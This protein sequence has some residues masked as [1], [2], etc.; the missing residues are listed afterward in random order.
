MP[1]SIGADRTARL[2][3]TTV[4]VPFTTTAPLIEDTNLSALKGFE[5][6]KLE[7][8]TNKQA[9]SPI[10]ST[11]PATRTEIPA[12]VLQQPLSQFSTLP[13]FGN[14]ASSTVTPDMPE[15]GKQYNSAVPFGL[16]RPWK[17][18]AVSTEPASSALLTFDTDNFAGTVFSRDSGA[19]FVFGTKSETVTDSKTDPVEKMETEDGQSQA[20]SSILDGPPT[21][22]NFNSFTSLIES[23]IDTM[24]TSLSPPTKNSVAV[25]D[26]PT[27]SQPCA[28]YTVGEYLID[29]ITCIFHRWSGT[30][31]TVVFNK[32]AELYAQYRLGLSSPYPSSWTCPSAS[33]NW[34]GVVE[35]F[36]SDFVELTM[37]DATE[38]VKAAKVEFLMNEL[39]RSIGEECETMDEDAYAGLRVCVQIF[40][41]Q[42]GYSDTS[43]RRSECRRRGG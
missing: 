42:E 29:N 9:A 24:E 3:S 18:P 26:A 31:R 5:V 1:E 28:P 36:E 7:F 19:P 25:E 33:M 35:N 13:L 23:C 39:E 11:H 15:C 21:E 16:H 30:N 41:S 37:P 27:N 34:S 2:A 8:L 32:F 40:V 17:D 22:A 14:L 20:Q 43:Y 10:W 12:S 6:P 4:L 38:A